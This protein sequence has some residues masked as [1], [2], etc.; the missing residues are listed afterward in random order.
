MIWSPHL[1]W[2]I[3]TATLDNWC[4]ITRWKPGALDWWLWASWVPSVILMSRIL[5]LQDVKNND[6]PV[7]K[8][9]LWAL[10]SELHWALGSYTYQFPLSLIFLHSKSIKEAIFLDSS[11]LYYCSLEIFFNFIDT[12]RNHLSLKQ[13]LLEG[14]G[15]WLF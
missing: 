5:T 15:L 1:S 12:Q 7:T 11:K 9:E 14:K 8:Q 2:R 3:G 13:N 4:S 6:P 10:D